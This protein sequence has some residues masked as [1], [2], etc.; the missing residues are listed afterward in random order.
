VISDCGLRIER[1]R[2]PDSFLNP[3]F[4][5]RNPQFSQLSYVPRDLP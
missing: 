3:Q 4:Q 2:G 1:Q 5:I